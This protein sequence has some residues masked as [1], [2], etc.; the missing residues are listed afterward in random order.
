MK[1]KYDKLAADVLP[2]ANK[3][4]QQRTYLNILYNSPVKEYYHTAV[5]Y[6]Y[7]AYA[8]IAERIIV[9]VLRI[10]HASLLLNMLVKHHCPLSPHK[11]ALAEYL[12]T[13]QNGH[14]LHI[15]CARYVQKQCIFNS[16]LKNILVNLTNLL[17]IKLLKVMIYFYLML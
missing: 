10:S 11:G 6:L 13:A 16:F 15:F 14:F 8:I 3:K 1:R 17:H 2:T 4:S 9:L 5:A 7:S 12:Q